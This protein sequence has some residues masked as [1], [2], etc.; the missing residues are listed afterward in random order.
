MKPDVKRILTKLSENKVELAIG[1]ELKSLS[2]KAESV[3]NKLNQE[4]DNAFEPI[5]RIEKISES[6]PSKIDGLKEF[7][8]ALGRMEIQFQNDVQKIRNIE[9]ELGTKIKPPK[10]IDIALKD[11]KEFQRFEEIYRKQI[12]EFI[13]ESKKYR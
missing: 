7:T 11:L 8:D 5:R 12:N 13:R 2:L 9:N 6:I 10:S 3:R 4:L 1:D